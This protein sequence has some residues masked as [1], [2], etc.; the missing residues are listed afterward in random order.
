MGR[1]D[2]KPCPFCGESV[3]LSGVAR[4]LY[5]EWSPV[6]IRC[7]TC[8]ARGPYKETWDEADEAWNERHIQKEGERDGHSKS[9][10]SY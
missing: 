9:A 10:E 5:D 3:L 8:G 4:D 7:E 6:L 1:K 2:R